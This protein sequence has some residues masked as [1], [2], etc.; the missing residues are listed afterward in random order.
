MVGP[1]GGDFL[2]QAAIARTMQKHPTAR[3]TTSSDD[4]AVGASVPFDARAFGVR[5]SEELRT[6][7]G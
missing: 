4:S 6:K 1:S 7:T 3:F 5:R 2:S